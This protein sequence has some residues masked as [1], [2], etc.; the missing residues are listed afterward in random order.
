[1]PKPSR[2]NASVW[3]VLLCLGVLIGLRLPHTL[4]YFHLNLRGTELIHH[5]AKGQSAMGAS[6]EDQTVSSE[7]PGCDR[8]EDTGS[9]KEFDQKIGVR[10]RRFAFLT[11]FLCGTPYELLKRDARDLQADIPEDST[12]A[13]LLARS[14]FADGHL[15][16]ARS[17]WHST[18]LNESILAYT[19]AK[20]A[21]QGQDPAR[22]ADILVSFGSWKDEPVVADSAPL[23]DLACAAFRDANRNNESVQSCLKLVDARP[24]SSASWVQL[25]SAYLH[26]GQVNQAIAAGQEAVALDPQN[27]GVHVALGA[28]LQNAG[29]MADADASYETAIRLDPSS[30][31]ARLALAASLLYQNRCIEAQAVLDQIG[32]QTADLSV[33]LAAQRAALTAQCD[34]QQTQPSSN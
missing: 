9:T 32:P 23:Y 25:S 15:D 31:E 3:L 2:Q 33:Q 8:R 10:F 28:C 1:M 34:L 27:P 17:I 14:A 12:V 6:S 22:A 18:S 30:A 26:F 20:E 4:S 16:E 19:F 29:M 21:Y 11:Q 24:K 13:W 7:M 5:Q